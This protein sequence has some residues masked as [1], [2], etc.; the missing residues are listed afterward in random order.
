LI[1]PKH[2]SV[3]SQFHIV[4]ATT[5]RMGIFGSELGKRVA[6]EWLQRQSEWR[7]ALMKVSFVPDHVHL[8]VRASSRRVAGRRCCQFDEFCSNDDEERV[9]TRWSEP[10]VAAERLCGIVRRLGQS[11]D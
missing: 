7:I 4:L 2:A 8:A 3:I 11:A 9:G 10:I 6:Q 5:N 1:K